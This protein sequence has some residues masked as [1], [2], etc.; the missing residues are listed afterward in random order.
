MKRWLFAAL[1]C[2]AALF[3][4]HTKAQAATCSVVFTESAILHASQLTNLQNCVNSIDNQNIGSNGVFA[5]Q[6]IP[7]TVGQATF[8]GSVP[9]TFPNGLS[10]GV[11]LAA[12]SGGIDTLNGPTVASGKNVVVFGD[13]ITVGL[14]INNQTAYGCTGSPGLCWADIVTAAFPGATE[15]NLGA[16]GTCVEQTTTS[17]SGC[18]NFTSAI[19]R[20]AST[21]LPYCGA[22]GN[23]IFILY[24]TN[25]IANVYDGANDT[26]INAVTFK[27][28][29]STIVAACEAAGTPGSQIVLGLIPWESIPT[30]NGPLLF[31]FN[32]AIA[33]V[34]RKYGTRLA[35]SYGATGQCPAT[36]MTDG[37][38][39]NNTG[40][41]NIGAAMLDAS[42]AN[43]VSTSSAYDALNGLT[44][45]GI[46]TTLLNVAGT[47]TV[48]GTTNLAGLSVNGNINGGSTVGSYLFLGTLGADIGSAGGL[49]FGSVTGS[50]SQLFTKFNTTVSGVACSDFGIG[51]SSTN[52]VCF[53]AT[54][55]VGVRGTTV[56]TVVKSKAN[57]STAGSVPPCFTAAGADCGVTVHEVIGTCAFS[58]STTCTPA[59]FSG[60]SVFTGATSY[61]C[62]ASGGAA[63]FAQTGS[64]SVGSQS[65]TGIVITAAVSNSQTVAYRCAG[66]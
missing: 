6:V 8:G 48:T 12:G 35:G 44:A 34:A 58:S 15:V 5:S 19:T 43:A 66:T 50:Y 7:T 63:T 13:S 37:Q 49:K 10:L 14:G 36:C 22:N 61:S 1:L 11:P 16:G 46:A 33:A 45:G 26:Q 3:S 41:A 30:Y 56:S 52:D 23:G 29:Y 59:V 21:L 40:H 60:A 4:A 39:P 25:D 65:T 57:G 9:Y 20:Y 38:H 54:G 51:N 24:G 18:K 55:D 28:N 53:A 62:T 64:L 31:R 47:V 32:G 17:G 42:Y 2:V 27:A